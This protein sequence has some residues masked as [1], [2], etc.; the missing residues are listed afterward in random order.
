MQVSD[1]VTVLR[2]GKV[3][4]TLSTSDT[5]KP[6]LARL[7][8]GREVVFRLEKSPVKRKGKLLDV[9]NLH[10]LNDRGLP[11]LCGVSFE[12]FGG[13]ILGVAGVSGNGQHELAE[14][15]TGLR[16]L[17]RGKMFLSKKDV[18]NCSARKMYGLMPMY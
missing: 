12:V 7:M 15:L 6:A 10:T 14:V 18:T 4:S 3:I 1:R 8:V 16:K 2:K 5:D 11:A 13:E 9:S 17:T